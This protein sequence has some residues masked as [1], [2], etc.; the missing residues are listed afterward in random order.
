MNDWNQVRWMEDLKSGI[1]KLSSTCLFLYTHWYRYLLLYH[2]VME[3]IVVVM[4]VVG[5]LR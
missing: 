3:V 4:V 5:W 1:Y 2:C